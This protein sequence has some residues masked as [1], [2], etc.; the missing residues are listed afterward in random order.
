MKGKGYFSKYKKYYHFTRLER[1]KNS[2]IIYF[3]KF[4]IFK[5]KKFFTHNIGNKKKMLSQFS[6]FFSFFYFFCLR[7]VPSFGRLKG[8]HVPHPQLP[9]PEPPSLEM[10]G[11]YSKTFPGFLCFNNNYIKTWNYKFQIWTRLQQ[12]LAFLVQPFPRLFD[13]LQLGMLTFS[14]FRKTI[15]SL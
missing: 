4:S 5:K 8:G 13:I 6:P 10:C 9:W 7:K 1:N 15:V 2:Q 12:I 3:R 14:F 11:I